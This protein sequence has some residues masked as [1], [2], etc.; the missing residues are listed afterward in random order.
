MLNFENA[1][2]NEI[3]G[4]YQTANLFL[5]LLKPWFETDNEYHGDK[6]ENIL[7]Q[8]F[9][10]ML[11]Q[12]LGPKDQLELIKA[13]GNYIKFNLLTVYKVAPSSKDLAEFEDIW[14]KFSN[15]FNLSD[16]LKAKAIKEYNS[17]LK[18]NFSAIAKSIERHKLTNSMNNILSGGFKQALY[19]EKNKLVIKVEKNLIGNDSGDYQSNLLIYLE[20]K[21]AEKFIKQLEDTLNPTNH[22]YY[23]MNYYWPLVSNIQQDSLDAKLD[24]LDSFYEIQGVGLE[25]TLNIKRT[26]SGISSYKLCNL[27][28][29]QSKDTSSVYELSKLIL[30]RIY[31]DKSNDQLRFVFNSYKYNW[32]NIL[33]SCLKQRFTDISESELNEK[34]RDE[35]ETYFYELTTPKSSLAADNLHKVSVTNDEYQAMKNSIGIK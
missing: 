12:N 33:M 3:N 24:Y 4:D 8:E 16:E 32:K 35:C 29:A 1:A 13:I 9:A 27:I 22:L 18:N 5:C 31:D 2:T 30:E 15:E 7:V 14:N 28:G 6:E 10:T 17:L 26:L 23:F 34:Y 21:I 11:S 19:S 20:Q 25:R